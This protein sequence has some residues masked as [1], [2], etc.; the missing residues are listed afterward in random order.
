[1]YEISVIL[2]VYNRIK[3]LRRC[4]ESVLNQTYSSIEL[5]IVDDGSNDGSEKICDEYNKNYANVKVIHKSNGGVS[6]ARNIGLENASGSYIGFVDSDDFIEANMYEIMASAIVNSD[7]VMCGFYK[8]GSVYSGVSSK[9]LVGKEKAIS[10]VIE[11]GKFK[12]YLWNKLFKKSIIV[13]NRLSF[14]HDIYTCEDLLFCI[15]YIDKMNNALLLPDVL[16]HYENNGND[17]L[18]NGKFTSKKMTIIDS[19]N[20]ISHI[21]IVKNNKKIYDEIMWR[22]T[23]HCLSLWNSLR[24]GNR[25]DK[26]NYLPILKK[27]I[28]NGDFQFILAEG[29]AV[30]YKLMFLLL[31]IF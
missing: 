5:I 6:S 10:N 18:S 1:M 20:K 8:N 29:Y 21:D 12:G 4:I 27:E 17:S 22:K 7:L 9:C 26:K 30:K 24:K 28:K 2:P 3:N 16:Y 25:E 31:K 19:Y 11:N 13:R 23:K 15:Q 14:A